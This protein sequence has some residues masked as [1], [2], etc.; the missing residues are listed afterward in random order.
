VG[1]YEVLAGRYTVATAGGWSALRWR[2]AAWESGAEGSEEMSEEKSNEQR[3]AAMADLCERAAVLCRRGDARVARVLE[4]ALDLNLESRDWQRCYHNGLVAAG[5][6]PAAIDAATDLPREPETPEA[7]HAR[8]VAEERARCLATLARL[9][10]QHRE[11]AATS[12]MQAHLAEAYACASRIVRD[13]H[14]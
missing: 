10:T 11:R 4:W 3:R 1:E 2:V 14:R 13:G 8:G 12:E 6:E 9:E 7:A 5:A